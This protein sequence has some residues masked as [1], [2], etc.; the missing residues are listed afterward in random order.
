MASE[1]E[2]LIEAIRETPD[3]DAPRL[4]MADWFADQGGPENEARADFIR[5]QIDRARLPDDDERQGESP[6]SELERL[7]ASPAWP[8][9]VSL[10]AVIPR[11]TPAGVHTRVWGRWPS[12]S[13]APW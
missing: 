2:R 8:Q 4:V 9:L 13:S 12:P 3:D 7:L 5:T 6:V 11:P 10:S 1:R